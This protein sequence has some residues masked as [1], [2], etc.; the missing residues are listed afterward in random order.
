MTKSDEEYSLSELALLFTRIPPVHFQAMVESIREGGLREPITLWRE[1]IIDGRHRYE[2][3]LQA[4]VEPH[5]VHLP[6]DAD[7]LKYVLD[8]NSARRHMSDSQRAIAAHRTWEEA[9]SGWPCLGLTD[10]ES[11]SLHSLT[12]QQAADLFH[13]SRRLAVHAGKVFRSNSQG[14]PE[15]RQAADQGDVAVSDASRVVD[16]P[17]EVQLR[18]LE[19]VQGGRSKTV[20]RAAKMV[21]GQTRDPQPDEGPRTVLP[22][23]PPGNVTLHRSELGDLH[24]LVERE[25]IDAIITNPPTSKESL[26]MLPDLAAFAAHALKP[27]GA[28]VVMATAEHLPEVLE[29]L[30]HPELHWACE[31]DLIFGEPWARLRG[32]HRLDLIRR[33]LLVFGKSHFRLSGGNDLVRVP[34]TEEAPTGVGQLIAGMRSI[35]ERFTQH[36]QVVCDPITMGRDTVAEAALTVGRRFIGAA[37]DQA[38]IDRIR[39]WLERAGISDM[40]SG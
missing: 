5:F 36:G 20:A 10:G 24:R 9:A 18:A 39:H 25:S 38:G 31:L 7:A 3:C 35:V 21:L 12:L 19:M 1:Q 13:V 27:G 28:M 34:P 37:E 14:I 23:Q 2:A 29:H 17:P 26:A 4:G 11:A 30:R 6:D 15:L 16:Q 40:S 8:E 32:K 22:E 33:P